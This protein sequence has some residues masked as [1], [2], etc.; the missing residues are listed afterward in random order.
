MDIVRGLTESDD[1]L[2]CLGSYSRIVLPALL[3]LL[4]EKKVIHSFRLYILLM[5]NIFLCHVYYE[6][7]CD[8]IQCNK[9]G[10]Y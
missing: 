3:R 4:G 10:R 7:C 5:A 1:G 6:M 2:E 9:I 8:V